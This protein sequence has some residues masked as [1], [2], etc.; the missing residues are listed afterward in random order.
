MRENHGVDSSSLI[1]YF[2]EEGAWDTDAIDRALKTNRLFLPPA[3]LTEVLSVRQPFPAL[4]EDLKT[5]P[6]LVT[7]EGF[8]ERAGLLRAALLQQGRKARLGDCLIAQ[9]CLDHNLPLIT[10]DKDFRHFVE[11]AGLRLFD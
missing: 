6:L 4:F 11:L 9:S 5:V 7:R 3:T 8:W 10:R 1:A 2:A